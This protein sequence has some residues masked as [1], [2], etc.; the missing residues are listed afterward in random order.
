M[1]YTKADHPAPARLMHH[2]HLVCIIA[3]VATGFFIHKPNFSLFGMSMNMVKKIHF[4]AAIAIVLNSIVRIYWSIFSSHA[5]IRYFLPEKKNQGTLF[6]MMA[7]YYFLRKTKPA[8]SK[9]NG[10]QKATYVIW[11]LVLFFQA[12]TG[13]AMYWN[14][15]PFWG[16]IVSAFGGLNNIHAVH[17]LVQWF[18]I[19]SVIFHVYLVI[20][21]DFKSFL[22]M[23]FGIESEETAY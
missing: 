11:T 7:Y 16:G 13:L 1:G 15:K 19:A 12:I 22:L 23:F 18:F 2:I 14:M 20:F 8:T 21:E 6:P 3:L 5:D 17:Y 4:Y 9:Y 10:W